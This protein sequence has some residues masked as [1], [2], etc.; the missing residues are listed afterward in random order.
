MNTTKRL[1]A[2]AEWLF[3]LPG[4]LFMAA[5]FMRSAQPRQYEPSHSAQRL[6][7]WFS[8]RPHL[9]LDVFLIA[10]PFAAFAIGCAVLVKSWSTEDDLRQTVAAVRT[11][12]A[13]LLIAAATLIAG[14]ILAVVGLHMI[15]D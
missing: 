10:L 5:L 9:G 4:S 6:I 1:I 12:M 2:A 8:V 13:T 14:G 7:D 3:I 15:T 11:Q